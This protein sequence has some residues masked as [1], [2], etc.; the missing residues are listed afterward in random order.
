MA[1]DYKKFETKEIASNKISKDIFPIIDSN[2]DFKE[3]RGKDAIIA[4]I[5]N[6]LMTPMGRYPFDPNYGSLL[7]KQVFEPMD[8]VT[9]ENIR[10]EVKDR[11]EMYEDRVSVEDVE[12]Q[13]SRDNKTAI[14]NVEFLIKDDDNKTK[15]SL[16]MKNLGSQMLI[17]SEDSTMPS[18]IWQG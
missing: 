7:Y 12:I 16:M 15:L 18:S 6:L 10:Y 9:Y 8:D 1:E 17:D 5:R 2:A 11:I 13:F 14:V 3:L 4:S